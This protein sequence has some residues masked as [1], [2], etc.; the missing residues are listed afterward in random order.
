MKGLSFSGPGREAVGAGGAAGGPEG[1]VEIPAL[2]LQHRRHLRG[3]G[4]GI[5]GDQRIQ[6][7][8]LSD[9]W[10]E[11]EHNLKIRQKPENIIR[12]VIEY[13]LRLSEC[14]F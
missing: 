14:I 13:N 5:I 8:K 11:S 12:N 4:I 9:R 6:I 10:T 7:S 3:R 2:R 1:G